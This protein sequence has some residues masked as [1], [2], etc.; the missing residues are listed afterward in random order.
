[1]FWQNQ[2]QFSSYCLVGWQEISPR[3]EQRMLQGLDSTQDLCSSRPSSYSE[4]FSQS[5]LPCLCIQFP[6]VRN[7][8]GPEDLRAD[9]NLCLGGGLFIHNMQQIR[10]CTL[11]D[12]KKNTK[13]FSNLTGNGLL[14][15]VSYLHSWE[16]QSSGFLFSL[17]LMTRRCSSYILSPKVLSLSI[18][19]WL[20]LPRQKICEPHS[21]DTLWFGTHFSFHYSLKKTLS[22]LI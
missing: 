1:M 4:A 17:G 19:L 21:S 18:G 11:K 6:S 14:K 7:V 10:V 13:L 12:R 22:V 16:I 9:S 2:L 8:K 15:E 3:P 20:N 5:S